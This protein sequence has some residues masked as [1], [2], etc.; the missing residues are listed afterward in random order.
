M[1][2]QLRFQEASCVSPGKLLIGGLTRE[3]IGGAS[4]SPIRSR[5]SAS[6]LISDQRVDA[7]PAYDAQSPMRSDAFP[8]L[9]I[10]VGPRKLPTVV[11]GKT[12]SNG[13]SSAVL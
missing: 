11:V 3:H 7:I 1:S 8:V 5:G 10:Q 6:L 2:S 12:P 13:R 4:A 9:T